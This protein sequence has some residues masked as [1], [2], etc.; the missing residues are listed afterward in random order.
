MVTIK[1]LSRDSVDD[2]IVAAA[3]KSIYALDGATGAK[4]WNYTAR[5]YHT[6]S[7]VVA[8]PPTD[9]N[10]NSN[11]DVLVA[12][13]DRLVMMLDGAKGKQLWSFNTTT[14]AADSGSYQQGTACSLSVRSAYYVSDI[15][16][17]GIADAAVISGTGDS[18]TQ[19]DRVSILALSGKTGQQLWEYAKAED[20]HGLKD[21]TK[22]ASPVAILDYNKDGTKDIVFADEQSFLRVING[23]DGTELDRTELDVFGSI[24][25]FTEIPDISGDG[26][27][28]VVALEF[29]EAGGGPDYAAIDAI[30]LR[31]SKVIWQVKVGDGRVDG[32]A[33]FSAASLSGVG[34]NLNDVLPRIAV[35]QRLENKLSLVL[36]DSKTGEQKWQ[37]ALGE[38]RSRDDLNKIYPVARIAT[39]GARDELAV[40][41]IDSKLY[42]LNPA[43]A[44]VIWSYGVTGEI[45]G[46]AF[47]V[48]PGG[49]NYIM[50]EE[51]YH[52]VTALSRQT[53]ISTTLSI[54]PSAETVVASSKVVIS[55]ALTPSFPG[56][57]IEIRYVDP[58]GAVTTR[59]LI[60]SKDG[61]YSDVFEPEMTGDWKVNVAFD[62]EGF[63]LDSTSRTISIKVIDEEKILVYM[64]KVPDDES[65]SYPI[66][67]FVDGGQVNDM[68]IN[69]ETKT[70]KIAINPSKEDGSLEIDLPRNVIDAFDKDYQVLINGKQAQYQEIESEDS[71]TRSLSIPFKQD[72]SE[73]TISGTYIVPEF[74]IVGPLLFAVVM[75]AVLATSMVMMRA[76]RRLY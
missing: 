55:G 54:Q 51:S 64:L 42:L 2:V 14:T 66:P 75:L 28:D 40:G 32:G 46:M 35:T 13:K 36:L 34:A 39:T 31:G 76:R 3:D 33:V 53:T 62:G 52:G 23:R 9:V 25:D 6:W 49:Q 21:G 70:L 30:D 50:V 12:T 8:S 43:D 24:W 16:G 69:K 15:D 45:G 7:A 60:L 47:A 11:S 4:L 48:A 65:V 17:D 10:D 68:S 74:S 57:L 71:S 22:N 59:P 38:E 63:Y 20:Y 5:E 18:C 29:I 1:D 73:I 19:K 41:S 44:S 72:S 26:I 67:Y 56:K 61:T 37:Y 58:K 27:A